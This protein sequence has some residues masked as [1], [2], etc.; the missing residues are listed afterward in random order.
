MTLLIEIF[1]IFSLIFSVFPRRNNWNHPQ[2]NGLI[3]DFT[4]IVSFIYEDF[5]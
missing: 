5:Q 2:F 1:V 4:G 3:N